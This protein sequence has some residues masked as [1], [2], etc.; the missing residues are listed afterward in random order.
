MIALLV[1]LAIALGFS[2]FC[3]IAE[4]VLLSV[5]TAYI[6]VLAE[7]GKKGAAR[8]RALKADID[9]PLAAILSLNTIAHT[10]G[11]A[12]VGAQ[13]ARVFG[14]GYLGVTSAILTLLILVFSE[15]IPKTLGSYY[16]RQLAPG[17]A[18]LLKYLIVIMYPL[19]WLS[20]QLT[21][22]IAAHPTLEGFSR[23]EFA[24]MANLG[25]QE[26]QLGEHEARI[27]Q[28]LFKLQKTRV[29]EV[30]TP[31]TVVF[32][33]PVDFTVEQFFSTQDS[34][35]FSRIPVYRQSPDQLEG[36]VLRA[37]LLL[38][39]ARGNGGNPLSNYQREL[40]GLPE[41]LSLLAA[42]DQ[43]L[44]KG[45]HMMHV[46]DEYG[47]IKGI[48]TLEDIFETLMGLEIVD[49]SDPAEDMQKLARRQWKRRARQ[50]G[51]DVDK[52]K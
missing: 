43:I 25:E 42:F 52:G 46:V 20:K 45:A 40:F 1:Y 34:K 30:M 24:A 33:L 47:V 29:E 11:A 35:H 3:S 37:D 9:I 15:I 32:S 17:I 18:F 10:V 2:F 31:S 12:G 36:F 28:N 50:M 38:A 8:L 48:I 14:S 26:G 22:K 23:E 6:R 41:K 51:I 16:W 39:M 19:V 44:Q 7:Q 21:R 27:L 49:E 13:A 5:S 4:A